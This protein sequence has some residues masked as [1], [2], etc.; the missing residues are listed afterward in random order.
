MRRAII[1]KKYIIPE[2][3][4]VKFS[5]ESIMDLS[6]GVSATTIASVGT[7]TVIEFSNDKSSYELG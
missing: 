3:E 1:M 5:S 4:A 7:A 2:I 6:G